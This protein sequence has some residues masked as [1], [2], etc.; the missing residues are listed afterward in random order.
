MC[1]PG[2]WHKHACAPQ[3]RR[4]LNEQTLVMTKDATMKE[5]TAT[6]KS[7][8]REHV[9]KELRR[10]INS[11]IVTK[12]FRRTYSIEKVVMIYLPFSISEYFISDIGRSKKEKRM[13]KIYISTDLSR[14]TMKPFTEMEQLDTECIHVENADIAEVHIDMDRIAEATRREILLRVLPMNLRKWKEFDLKLIDTKLIYRPYY[15]VMYKLFGKY[16]IFK[17]F[18]DCYNL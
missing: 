4:R 3:V 16:K 2:R 1:A 5:I 7:K 12:L 18:G 14:D 15:V 9:E 8:D 6:V 10:I 17:T 11:M 13:E